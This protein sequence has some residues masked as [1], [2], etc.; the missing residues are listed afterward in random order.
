M[1]A[2]KEMMKSAESARCCRY[3]GPA[4]LPQPAKCEANDKG[5]AMSRTLIHELRKS[6]R[7]DCTSVGPLPWP[8]GLCEYV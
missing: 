6:R 1:I 8:N 4:V 7:A 3:D 2:Q 5:T